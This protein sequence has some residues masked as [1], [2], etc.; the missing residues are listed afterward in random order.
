MSEGAS[1]GGFAARLLGRADGRFNALRPQIANTFAAEGSDGAPLLERS[2]EIAVQAPRAAEPAPPSAR[3]R[4]A[5]PH[6]SVQDLQLMPAAVDPPELAPVAP[7]AARA[8]ASPP[9]PHMVPKADE[10]SEHA[11]ITTTEVVTRETVIEQPSRVQ[12]SQL[13]PRGDSL[14][15]VVTQLLGPQ[16]DE[17]SARPG[18]EETASADPFRPAAPQ[19]VD[20]T[21]APSPQ[22]PLQ[23]HIG[24]L[25]IAPE[26]R[27]LEPAAAPVP[28]WQPPLSLDAYR[29]SRSRAQ[30]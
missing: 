3:T 22:Q 26:P 18:H 20:A 25:V 12:P 29:A 28:Q 10:V 2:E 4:P 6:E 14:L 1:P 11:A 23:I 7:A 24:E 16:L 9:A 15:S 30:P 17:A 21:A 13:G 19:A 8:E 5:E 27:A